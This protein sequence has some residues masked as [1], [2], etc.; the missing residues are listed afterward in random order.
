MK[1]FIPLILALALQSSLT[2]AEPEAGRATFTAYGSLA[3]NM[4][5]ALKAIGVQPLDT[6]DEYV[7]LYGP[8]SCRANHATQLYSPDY[9]VNMNHSCSEPAVS[10]VATAKMLVDA[11]RSCGIEQKAPQGET[12]YN[13]RDIECTVVKAA[14]ASLPNKMNKRFRCVLK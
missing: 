2:K 8:M 3:V 12:L 11:L 7:Y 6:R 14:K 10:D 1:K 13:V 4:I 5:E 9:L